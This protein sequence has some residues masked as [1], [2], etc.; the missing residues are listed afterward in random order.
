MPNSLY[1]LPVLAALL[2]LLGVGAA[3]AQVSTVCTF[4]AGPRAGTSVDYAATGRRSR[5][6]RRASTE[7]AAPD[8][9]AAATRGG[10][11]A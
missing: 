4:T 9:S 1:L 8:T 11:S 6:E 7:W 5:S 10:P 3:A 2:L